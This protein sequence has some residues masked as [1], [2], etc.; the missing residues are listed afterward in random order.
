MMF[1]NLTDLAVHFDSHSK[2]ELI[3]F[4]VYQMFMTGTAAL[5]KSEN[6]DKPPNMGNFDV[7]VDLDGS[8]DLGC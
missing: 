3:V 4:I 6:E 8:D 2:E 7:K 5:V 1:S